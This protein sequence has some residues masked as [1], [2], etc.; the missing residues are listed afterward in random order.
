MDT[1]NDL[2]LAG[3]SETPAGEIVL[4]GGV[5]T[6][7]TSRDGGLNFE[8]TMLT[9][10]LSLTAAAASGDRVILIGQGGIKLKTVRERP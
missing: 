1:D 7:L 4:V 10:R 8:R 3:G 9:D 2:T 5:G 6:V